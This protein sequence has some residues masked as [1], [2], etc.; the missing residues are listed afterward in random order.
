MAKIDSEQWMFDELPPRKLTQ[1]D[2]VSAR[3]E[4]RSMLS[5]VSDRTRGMGGVQRP[6]CHDELR[7]AIN[8]MQSA[9][10]ALMLTA[11]VAEEARA[12]QRADAIAAH[13]AA[14]LRASR[15]LGGL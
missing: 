15:M 3:D 1:S 8:A 7:S 13:R 6:G 12:K 5:S 10:R 2:Y 14:V 4:A 9:F 11:Y